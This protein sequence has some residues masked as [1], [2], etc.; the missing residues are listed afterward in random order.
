MNLEV[1]EYANK[2]GVLLPVLL[3]MVVIVYIPKIMQLM[4]S[5][6]MRK[7]NYLTTLHSNAFLTE[8]VQK[9]LKDEI[10]NA[11]FKSI[12]GFRVGTLFRE[13]LT[14]LHNQDRDRFT[15]RKIRMAESYMDIEKNDIV[16]KFDWFN[17]ISHFIDII[18][19]ILLAIVYIAFWINFV[20]QASIFTFL[21]TLAVSFVSAILFF[22]FAYQLA[23]FRYA[24]LLKQ[25]IEEFK[26]KSNTIDS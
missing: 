13:K 16:V 12:H 3:F 18:S 19:L 15:W 20:Y 24:K 10:N 2:A 11:A 8:D 23:Q 14:K 7:I 9:M 21:I 17:K 1:L 5:W 25:D 26:N 6:K 4:D 22:L